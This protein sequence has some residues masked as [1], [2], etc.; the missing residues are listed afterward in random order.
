[1]ST[2]DLMIIQ[3]TLSLQLQLCTKI[4]KE[5]NRIM[6]T[7][8]RKTHTFQALIKAQYNHVRPSVCKFSKYLFCPI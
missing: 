4:N 2:K 3:I 5:D 1:M 6:Q 8:D 7:K